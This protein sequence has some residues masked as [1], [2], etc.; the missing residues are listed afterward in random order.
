M[1]YKIIWA[2]FIADFIFQSDSM[3]KNKSSSNE[4]LLKHIL[5]YSAFLF[6]FFA[7]DGWKFNIINASLFALVNGVAH[8]ITD[9]FTSRWSKGLWEK[10]QVH[11]FFVV[12]GFD[13]AIHLSIL[14][15]TLPLLGK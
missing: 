12:I 1:I 14:V 9:Y 4:W 2:H 10:G 3:A 7:V 6:A 15:A 8:L 11:N 13:Q 5:T